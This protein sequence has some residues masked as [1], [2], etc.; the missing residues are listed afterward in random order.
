VTYQSK[1]ITRTGFIQS[2]KLNHDFSV[3]VEIHYTVEGNVHYTNH[4]LN[5]KISL[6][7]VNTLVKDIRGI[8]D[9]IANHWNK[10][11]KELKGEQ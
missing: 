11:D 5:L 4:I 10:L 2:I 8:L 9:G 6:W 3:T 7:N 1:K